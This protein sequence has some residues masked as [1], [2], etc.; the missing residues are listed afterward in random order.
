MK[1]LRERVFAIEGRDVAVPI[2]LAAAVL[3]TVATLWLVNHW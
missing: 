2:G 1:E 3:F